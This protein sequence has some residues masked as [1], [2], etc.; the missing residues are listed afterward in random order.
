[1]GASGVDRQGDHKGRPYVKSVVSGL[2][3]VA[4]YLWSF[5]YASRQTLP[6]LDKLPDVGYNCNVATIV[7][8]L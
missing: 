8:T 2:L 4:Y 3:S 1:M 5:F 6:K 7:A